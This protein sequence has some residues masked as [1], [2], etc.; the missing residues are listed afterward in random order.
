[1]T[2]FLNHDERLA[3]TKAALRIVEREDIKRPAAMLSDNTL[4]MND[5]DLVAWLAAWGDDNATMMMR[6]YYTRPLYPITED[7]LS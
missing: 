2:N 3:M 5:F 7:D 6:W 4:N 1:M